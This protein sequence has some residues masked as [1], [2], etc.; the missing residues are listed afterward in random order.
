MRRSRVL[1]AAA[2]A[3]AS[4]LLLFGALA[5]AGRTA[6]AS[7]VALRHLQVTQVEYRLGLSRGSVRAGL[8][9]LEVIDRGQDPHDL[10]LR[11]LGSGRRGAIPQLRP[12][13]RWDGVINLRPGLY[14]LWCSLPEHARLGMRATLR[15][16]R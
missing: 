9:A 11:A 5:H 4:A 1:A 6:R 15:V 16:V 3:I 14:A 12:G 8:L 13:Q 2:S 7:R 10:R